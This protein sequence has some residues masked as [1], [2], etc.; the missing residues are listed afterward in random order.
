MNDYEQ[1]LLYLNMQGCS[2]FFAF[3]GACEKY[4]NLLSPKVLNMYEYSSLLITR[5]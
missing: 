3:N 4:S 1:R 5:R 2:D